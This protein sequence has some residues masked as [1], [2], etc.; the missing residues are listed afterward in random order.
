MKPARLSV[1]SKTHQDRQ[2][3]HYFTDGGMDKTS[4]TFC[5]HLPIQPE[6][7]NRNK[8]LII[9]AHMMHAFALETNVDKYDVNARQINC[10][11]RSNAEKCVQS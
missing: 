5:I 11:L 9:L 2:G 8:L 7:S 10:F 1:V 4:N 3:V 6:H